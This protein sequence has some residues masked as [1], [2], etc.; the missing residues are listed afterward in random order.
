MWTSG[1]IRRT[2]LEYF[3]QRQHTVVESSSLVPVNDPTL[4]FANAGMNQFKDVFLGIDK[5][6]YNRATTSQKCVRAGGKHNDLDTVGR[7]PRHHTFFEMLGNFSFG[8]LF[9]RRCYYVCMGF[10][11]QSSRNS[12]RTT[13][14]DPF[15]QMMMRPTNYGRRW[16]I[17]Q[18]QE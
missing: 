10:F 9:Q 7:T 1:E 6:N 12:F 4:L 5:R 8:E 11:D 16:P 15:I 17:F 2:F 3:E 13:L 18:W 14:G